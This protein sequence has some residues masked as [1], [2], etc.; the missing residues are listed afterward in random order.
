MGATGDAGRAEE[1]VVV[2]GR[3]DPEWVRNR[4]IDEVCDPA[5]ILVPAGLKGDS[6]LLEVVQHVRDVVEEEVLYAAPCAVQH[7]TKML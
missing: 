4:A 3:N 2:D 5:V 1:V 6:V 7:Y